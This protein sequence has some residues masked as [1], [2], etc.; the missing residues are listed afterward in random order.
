MILS[1]LVRTRLRLVRF[2]FAGCT[3]MTSRACRDSR[4]KA[5]ISHR[6]ECVFTW[7]WL[8]PNVVSRLRGNDRLRQF[9]GI[10]EK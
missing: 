7:D 5:G 8:P 1:P 10:G 9:R 3:C 4:R 6:Q 2:I